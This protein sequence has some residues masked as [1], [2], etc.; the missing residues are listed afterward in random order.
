MK[1]DA[2]LFLAISFA[3]FCA[4]FGLK[5]FRIIK[6][7]LDDYIKGIQHDFSEAEELLLALKQKKSCQF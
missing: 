6:A 7:F 1:F 2:S 4:L 3:L 5:I